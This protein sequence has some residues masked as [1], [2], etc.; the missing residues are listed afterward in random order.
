VAVGPLA[1]VP[2]GA[3]VHAGLEAPCKRQPVVGAVGLL[4]LAGRLGGLDH[5]ESRRHH[6]QLEPDEQ[7]G[8]LGSLA[9]PVATN[10]GG[11]ADDVPAAL[12]ADRAPDPRVEQAAGS[13]GF[14]VVVPTV[15][16]GLRMAFFCRIAIAGQM[17]SMASTSGFSIRSRTAGVRRERFHVA[18]LALRVDR[19]E[20]ERRLARPA[21]ARHHDEPARGQRHVD[22]LQVV[23][24]RPAHDDVAELRHWLGHSLVETEAFRWRPDPPILPETRD[25]PRARPPSL[26]CLGPRYGSQA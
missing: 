16:R 20:G 13:R 1:A 23:S 7:A 17:P 18:A 25:R 8:A 3:A 5:L 9:R 11:L 15:D 2:V 22:V 4:F 24:T 21:D 14:S 12:P 26:P 6:R 10:L 19:V